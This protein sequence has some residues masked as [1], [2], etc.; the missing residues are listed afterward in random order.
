MDQSEASVCVTWSTLTNK[1]P[2]LR[3]LMNRWSLSYS[4][5]DSFGKKSDKNH[6]SLLI[7]Q[8]WWTFNQAASRTHDKVADSRDWGIGTKWDSLHPGPNKDWLGLSEFHSLYIC[9]YVSSSLSFL[10]RGSA[11]T[12]RTVH[13]SPSGGWEKKGGGRV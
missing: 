12:I 1:K 3:S 6:W 5:K 2:V 13:L 11:E 9:L 4:L 8:S 7:A 10:L